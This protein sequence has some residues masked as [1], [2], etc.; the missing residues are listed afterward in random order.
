MSE[1]LIVP[2]PNTTGEINL[3]T[4]MVR[5][6][7]FDRT[8][9]DNPI[10][11][12]LDFSDG[13]IARAREFAI[14]M[15]NAIPPFVH[16]LQHDNVPAN[17]RYPFLLAIIYHLFVA[18]AAQLSRKDIDYSA[19]NMTVD[20]NKRRLEFYMKWSQAFKTESESTIKTLKV[21]ANLESAY[22]QVG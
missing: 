1:T 4:E 15:L 2:G 6:F 10:E 18:K 3:S 21:A 8:I 13:E 11:M 20:L 14:M 16:Q 17:W 12:D 9:E 22:G 19:G 7:I 5:H